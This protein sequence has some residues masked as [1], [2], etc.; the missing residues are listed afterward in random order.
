MKF[1]YIIIIILLFVFYYIQENNILENN[2]LEDNIQENHSEIVFKNNLD[3]L[4][5]SYP[6]FIKSK[7]KKYVLEPGDILYIPKNRP[8]LCFSDVGINA[9]INYW[10]INQDIFLDSSPRHI[11]NKYSLVNEVKNNIIN[12]LLQNDIDNFLTII[13]T[14]KE[15]TPVKKDDTQSI[16]Y[17]TVPQMILRKQH[18]PNLS[19]A[20]GQNQEI[21]SMLNLQKYKPD[22][23]KNSILKNNKFNNINFWLNTGDLNTGLHVDTYEGFLLQIIGKKTVYLFDD[24]RNIYLKKF[25]IL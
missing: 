25:P 12:N 8:H 13:S 10:D 15:I 4:K 9:S 16:E 18:N 7:Y 19:L 23:L 14:N 11:K 5:D 24:S 17:I 6:N 2:A 3:I 22:I 20:I 21:I 1:I